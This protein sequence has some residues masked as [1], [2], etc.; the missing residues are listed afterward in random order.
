MK[1]IEEKKAT[2][3]ILPN[4]RMQKGV[5]QPSKEKY[6]QEGAN[7]YSLIGALE[8]N[9]SNSSDM[10]SDDTLMIEPIRIARQ[11]LFRIHR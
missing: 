9:A 6:L 8:S 11:L 2:D 1:K 7:K 3:S 5:S 10:S 4:A